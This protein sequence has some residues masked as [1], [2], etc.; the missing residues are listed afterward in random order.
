MVQAIDANPA[1][2]IRRVSGEL[3]FSQSNIHNLGK[4]HPELLKWTSRYQNIAKLLI[5]SSIQFVLF[6]YERG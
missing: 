1:S 2:S 5:N 4:K 6:K 3:D